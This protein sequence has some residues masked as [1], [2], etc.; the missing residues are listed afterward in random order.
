[1]KSFSKLGTALVLG[2]SIMLPSAL[3]Q[4]TEKTKAQIIKNLLQ[5]PK[6]SKEKA[7]NS[8]SFSVDLNKDLQG[9][10]FDRKKPFTDRNF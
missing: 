10:P 2:A 3:G 1:M 7:E 8:D 5:T 9:T 4:K 6:Q